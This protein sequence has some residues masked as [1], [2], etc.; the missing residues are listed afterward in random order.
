MHEA[1]SETRLPEQV[2]H[3]L[4]GQRKTCSNSDLRFMFSFNSSTPAVI[5]LPISQR[6]RQKDT[7]FFQLDSRWEDILPY[8]L[9][10]NRFRLR[11]PRCKKNTCWKR[12]TGRPQPQP[13]AGAIGDEVKTHIARFHC[14]PRS[15]PECIRCV[16]AKKE[17]LCKRHPSPNEE[18]G[19]AS[20]GGRKNDRGPPAFSIHECSIFLFVEVVTKAIETKGTAATL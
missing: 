1:Q 20:E 6:R 8:V 10:S 14:I 3:G 15:R 16:C 19:V 5:C 18:P 4:N 9:S 13:V 11:S 2:K 7:F 12:P 17:T